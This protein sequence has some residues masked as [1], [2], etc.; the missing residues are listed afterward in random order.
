MDPGSVEMPLKFVRYVLVQIRRGPRVR[1]H[2]CLGRFEQL[3]QIVQDND[4]VELEALAG[5]GPERTARILEA[6]RQTL[7]PLALEVRSE[8][9]R[10]G[11]EG[12]CRIEATA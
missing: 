3:A 5:F 10:V 8:E 6:F 7:D 11:K 12:R 2:H 9:R 4:A 1:R